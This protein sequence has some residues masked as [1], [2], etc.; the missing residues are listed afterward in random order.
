MTFPFT[1][2]S[3]LKILKRLDAPTAG[4]EHES[5]GAESAGV[6]GADENGGLTPLLNFSMTTT[7]SGLPLVVTRTSMRV[8]VEVGEPTR[9]L[10]PVTR[11]ASS[12]K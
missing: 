11:C 5:V 3:A 10:P 7:V 2:R 6:L 12:R 1:E 9:I 8:G 4:A